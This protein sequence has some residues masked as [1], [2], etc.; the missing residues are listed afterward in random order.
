MINI[1]L[2]SERSRNPVL[3]KSITL[4]ELTDSIITKDYSPNP[5]MPLRQ[6]FMQYRPDS[7]EMWKVNRR[8]SQKD[9]SQQPQP[10]QLQPPASYNQGKSSSNSK[11]VS[12]FA[13][14]KR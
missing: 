12:E 6:P 4:G 14:E 8:I 2:D 5:F 13:F 7:A 3:T 9:G 11:M 10:Q 1:D